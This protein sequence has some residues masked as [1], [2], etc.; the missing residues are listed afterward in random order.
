MAT[1]FLTVFP[2]FNADHELDESL[3]KIPGVVE[4]GLFIGMADLVITLNG[5]SQPIFLRRGGK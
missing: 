1:I 5:K 2:E 4:N 3:N